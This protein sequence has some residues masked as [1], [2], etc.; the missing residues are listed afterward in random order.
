[1]TKVDVFPL[2]SQEVSF[3]LVKS[4]LANIICNMNSMTGGRAPFTHLGGVGEESLLQYRC[5]I[6]ML[7][8][9]YSLQSKKITRRLVLLH[10]PEPTK[11]F[12]VPRQQ[13]L[14]VPAQATPKVTP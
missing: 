1:M 3:R 7:P 10:K 13:L 11:N 2:Y 12:H 9:L 6:G 5:L 4:F 8:K 14:T